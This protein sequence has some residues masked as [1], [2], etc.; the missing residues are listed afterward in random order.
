[1]NN[2]L[3]SSPTRDVEPLKDVVDV[4]NWQKP[5]AVEE[6]DAERDAAAAAAAPKDAY[7]VW[8]AAKTKPNLY[9]VVKGLEPT[10]GSVLASM[11]GGGNPGIRGR[12]RVVAAKAVQTFDPE[13]GASLPTWVSQQ[14]R[15]LGRDIRKSN[16]DIHVPD[17]VMMDAYAIYRAESE[18]EDELGREP[19]VEEVSDKAHLSVKRVADVRRKNR[20]QASES[21]ASGGD[22]VATVGDGTAVDH[23]PE[24][25]DYVYRES[26]TN[27]RKLMEYTVGYG[28]AKVLGSKEIM[29]RLRLTPTQLTR[30]KARLSMR[31]VE[32]A[33]NLEEV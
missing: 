14:L 5:E 17:G 15:Q 10:I 16:T 1:M 8:R 32:V 3:E 9:N 26:D 33:R 30:R 23:Y 27:D 20:R 18:L 19:T 13:A 21:S 28:G 29:E 6:T 12:A 4:L 31:I 22:E 25:M 11:G 7:E 2:E 24:A